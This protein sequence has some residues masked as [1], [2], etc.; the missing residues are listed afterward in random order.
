M[1]IASVKKRDKSKP[2]LGITEAR[3]FI[4]VSGKTSTKFVPIFSKAIDFIKCSDLK[5]LTNLY[6]C[7][8]LDSSS[9]EI[10]TSITF[11]TT[12]I[13]SASLIAL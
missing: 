1:F 8:K 5:V 2:F 13:S 11:R 12:G 6:S 7:A 3:V 10:R 4:L 9:I